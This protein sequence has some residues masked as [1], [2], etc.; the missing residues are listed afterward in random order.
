MLK[1]GQKYTWIYQEETIGFADG[2]EE[3][4]REKKVFNDES[5]LFVLCNRKSKIVNC[6]D[7]EDC[8]RDRKGEVVIST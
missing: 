8:K 7:G 6:W 1:I 4:L 3:V 2:W 5:T